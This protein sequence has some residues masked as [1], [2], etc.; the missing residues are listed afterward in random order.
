V[1]PMAREQGG[2]TVRIKTKE[3]S[4]QRI[5]FDNLLCRVDIFSTSFVGC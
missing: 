3:V 4:T 1:A 5:D 2:L